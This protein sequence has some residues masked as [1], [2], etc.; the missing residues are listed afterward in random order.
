MTPFHIPERL[1]FSS[2]LIDFNSPGESSAFCKEEISKYSGG[3]TFL[4]NS[5]TAAIEVA[6]LT[7][8]QQRP[9]LKVVGLPTYTFASVLSAVLKLG[10]TPVLIDVDRTTGVITSETL[11]RLG[12]PIDILIA[13]HYAT[14]LVDFSEL[15]K[16]LPEIVVIED[17]AQAFGDP[18]LLSVERVR[19]DFVCFSF[20]QTKN[21]HCGFGGSLSINSSRFDAELV[22]HIID[23]G[24]NR[25]GVVRSQIKSYEFVC[26]G[27]SYAL[28]EGLAFA[29]R[30]QILAMPE[31]LRAREIIFHRYSRGLESAIGD[32]ISFSSASA[33]EKSNFHSVFVLTKDSESGLREYLGKY[34]IPAYQGYSP[35]HSAAGVLGHGMH[36]G[37][38]QGASWLSSRINRLPIYPSLP[39]EV[40]DECISRITEWSQAN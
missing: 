28:P 39:L 32:S 8:K 29:L 11:E 40:V 20:H 9:D 13:N 10:F 31:I 18:R 30:K 7:L 22:D 17:A 37:A 33:V 38:Y 5:C 23:R 21:I 24:T 26:V 27:G 4:T 1:E 15:K 3:K 14:H 16:I 36:I 25:N 35:L 19:G 2:E 34:G 12:C 6:L